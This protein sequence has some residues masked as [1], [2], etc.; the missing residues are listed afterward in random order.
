M[1]SEE[2]GHER[3][4]YGIITIVLGMVVLIL[5]LIVVLHQYSRTTHWMRSR[6]RRWIYRNLWHYD[7]PRM[8]LPENTMGTAS[9]TSSSTG[10]E[11][12]M[13]SSP[14]TLKIVESSLSKNNRKSHGSNISRGSMHLKE[15]PAGNKIQLTSS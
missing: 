14:I 2:D 3:W 4:T 1:D 6:L 13:G 12:S 10:S 15:K 11:M 8:L 7:N 5:F 9:E